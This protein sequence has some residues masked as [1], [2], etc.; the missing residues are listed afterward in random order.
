MS[1]KDYIKV[2]EY[3]VTVDDVSDLDDIY[4]ELETQGIAPPNTELTRSILLAERRPNSR[5]THYWLTDWEAEQLR[6][7]PR[8]RS[9]EIH[10][11]YRGI[12]A[13]TTG[14]TQT[15]TN[16]NKSSSTASTMKNFGLLRCTEG[17]QR[18][19]WGS[20]GTTTQTGTITLNA[21][22][23][24]VDVVVI[25]ENGL[26]WNHPEFA[27]NADGTGGTRTIQYNW[28]QHDPAVKGTAASNYSYGTGSHSTHVAGTVAGNTQGWARDANIYNIYYLAGDTANYNFPYVMDYVR[29]FHAN[30]SINPGTGRKNPTVT[31]NSW[32]MSIFPNEWSFSDITAVTY[33]GTRYTPS[34]SVTYN[35]ISGVFTANTKLAD[36]AGLENTGNRI[37]HQVLLLTPAHE[38]YPNLRPGRKMVDRCITPI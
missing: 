14:Y 15:S 25:D 37:L 19:G 23:K 38:Y 18:A 22:G 7:D 1:L 30:K 34:S 20:D 16:W 9:V 8:I 4:N 36:L 21:T 12:T 26:V 13:G 29:Q 6:N 28:G 11:R 3:I 31:N 5:N 17:A 24:N 27:A 10:P 33:R 35:G 2:K 32:G